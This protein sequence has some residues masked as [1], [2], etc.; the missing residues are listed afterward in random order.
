D[1]NREYYYEDRGDAWMAFHEYNKAISDYDVYVRELC[2]SAFPYYRRAAAFLAKG[3]SE[4]ASDDYKRAAAVFEKYIR[5]E[6]GTSDNYEGLAWLLATCPVDEIRDGHRAL[7]LAMKL[8]DVDVDG[9]KYFRDDILAAA[10][11]EVG[12]F[13]MAIHHE[14][15][16]IGACRPC[17]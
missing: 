14:L 4:N 8:L 17:R 10:W 11:A 15:L 5:Q 3:D 2:D 16:E 6:P 13:D 1:V 7:S 12:N 9:G